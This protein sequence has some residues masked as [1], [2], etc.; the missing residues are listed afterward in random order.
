MRVVTGGDWS[1]GFGSDRSLEAALI[2]KRL[3]EGLREGYAELMSEPLPEQFDGLLKQLS[4]N[5]DEHCTGGFPDR[6]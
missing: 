4:G 5:S 1:A 6:D 3:G 2:Y